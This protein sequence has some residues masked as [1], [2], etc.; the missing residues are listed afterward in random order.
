MRLDEVEYATFSEISFQDA[1]AACLGV[2][3]QPAHYSASA[4]LR[5]TTS[6]ALTCCISP[7]ANDSRA[8]TDRALVFAVADWRYSET[9]STHW[10]TLATI[11]SKL[12]GELKQV[13]RYGSHWEKIG[14]QGSDPIT[15]LRSAGYLGLLHLLFLASQ[16]TALAQQCYNVSIQQR[17]QFPLAITGLNLT[18]M[19][20]AA[21]RSGRLKIERNRS[22]S[23][24]PGRQSAASDRF[25]VASCKLYVALWHSYI[26]TW[27][28]RHCTIENS[29][30]VLSS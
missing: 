15:D 24:V 20:M 3:I 8:A 23:T 18:R 12:T 28:S 9:L 14:F 16:A 11:Y 26:T 6:S 21:I 19:V 27:T 30:E 5:H 2:T 7:P 4:V 1:L 29:H 17:S 25:L 22:G 10:Q 13:Y